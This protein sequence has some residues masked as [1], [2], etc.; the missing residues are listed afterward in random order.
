MLSNRHPA[1]LQGGLALATLLIAVASLCAGQYH[2]SLSDVF[3]QLGH[4]SPA[5]GV[6]GQIVWSVRLPRVIMALLA[7]GAL[8]LCGATL[9]GV[10]QN[11]LVDPHIIGVTSGSAFGGTLAILL[12]LDTVLMMTSTFGFGLLALMLVYLIAALQGRENTLVLILSGIILSGFFAALVSL[13]QYLADTEETLPNIVFW[14]LGSFATASWH[15]VAIMALANQPAGAGGERRARSRRLGHRA[16]PRRAAM[17]RGAGGRTGGGQ[18]QHRLGGT[19]DPASGTAA[20]RRRPPPSAAHRLLARRR[21]ND[22]GRRSGPLADP[23]RDTR[24]DHYR[25]ARR[26]AVYL[27]TDPLTSSGDGLMNMSL[28]LAELRYGHRQPLFRPLSLQCLPGEIWAVLG[29]NGRGKSTLLDTL[30]G[31]LPPLG[32]SFHSEGGIAIVPQSFRP[33]FNWQVREVVLM[34]RA[35]Q[36]SLFAQPAVDDERRVEEALRQLSIADLAGRAF[37]SLSGGQQQLVLIARALVGAS[38]NILLDEPCSALD[39]SNQQVVLQLIS[40]LAHRQSR[41]VI[42][43]THDPTHA[44]QVASHTLLLLPDGEW[45]AG[46]SG[47]VLSEPHLQRA[48]GLAVRKIDYP[49]SDSPLLAPQFTIRR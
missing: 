44:L 18:R 12:G 29:A 15:K 17:L 43:T 7:G 19:G 27:A 22:R 46:R 41:T 6:A 42:F 5:D 25:V 1:L 14:L 36:V 40:D 30:T 4:L 24:R 20:G 3:S 33:A 9:Q 37:R 2:L 34:G 23:G 35:R 13:M 38:Q 39:L 26:P 47:E 32:G 21:I 8:G 49:G 45:L 28:R 10:F 31:V 11:P 16:A 48:Y